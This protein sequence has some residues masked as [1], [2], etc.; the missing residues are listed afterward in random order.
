MP[1]VTPPEYSFPA[2]SIFND[3]YAQ[4]KKDNKL[5]A[6][7]DDYDNDTPTPKDVIITGTP[8][9]PETDPTLGVK[10]DLPQVDLPR[11][12]Q[13]RNRLVA[14]GDSLT[15][16]FQSNAILNTD[17]SYPAIIANELGWAASFRHPKY[18]GHGGLPLNIELLMRTLEQ[19]F[20]PEI[21]WWE[22]ALAGFHVRQFMAEVEDWWERGP[23]SHVPE[24]TELNHNLAV[25][26]WDVRDALDRTANNCKAWIKA[27][28]NQ[29]L[30]QLVESA[31]ERAALRVY[32]YSEVNTARNDLTAF[33]QAREL[34]EQGNIKN[35]SGDGIETLL[36]LL[37]ANNALSAM[38]ALQVKWSGAGYDSLAE[39]SQYNVWA[40]LHFEAEFRQVVAE[41][42]KIK[43][44]HVIFGTVPHVTVVPI[45]RGVDRKVRTGSR[46][47]PFYTRPWIKDGDFDQNHD[48]CI[49]ENQARAIDS[50]VDQYNYVIT[51]LVRKARQEGRDWYVFDIAGMLDSLASRRYITDATARPDWWSPYQLPPELSTLSPKPDSKFF[52]GDRTGR[53]LQG[54]IFALDGVHPTTIGY[55][56]VAQEFINI[57]QMAGVKFYKGD[58]GTERTG[59]VRVDFGRLLQLDS[60]MSDPPR[61]IG[62]DL[63]LIG[64]F[65]QKIDFITRML[66]P[67]S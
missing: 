17:L 28:K 63:S 35:G 55:G 60:L 66:R 15:H 14:I 51:D 12:E 58:G 46:Y 20:G 47:F 1:Q 38:L 30:K 48:P 27:P 5:S 10:V 7:P 62:A 33:G 25:F 50:A 61:S 11:E 57:M 45:A 41:V 39:K 4:L 32:N 29:F 8:R 40:P 19:R 26:G 42:K 56:L 49:T 59:P 64:W 16:G 54:G 67:G 9:K 52:V 21:D 37:G 34:G 2:D 18:D 36:V 24:T 43:A 6:N 3:V 23:G 65:D 13:P 44:Q 22:L 31:N 53:R